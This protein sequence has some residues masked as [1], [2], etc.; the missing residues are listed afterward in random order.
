MYHQTSLI[1]SISFFITER[2]ILLY[3]GKSEVNV[4]EIMILKAQFLLSRVW[5]ALIHCIQCVHT[6]FPSKPASTLRFL[7]RYTETVVIYRYFS[8]FWTLLF[9][10]EMCIFLEF[11]IILTHKSID[12][13]LH[14]VYVLII[15]SKCRN[16]HLQYIVLLDK[17]ALSFSVDWCTEEIPYFHVTNSFEGV[18]NPSCFPPGCVYVCGMYIDMY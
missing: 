3:K 14:G 7:F 10:G 11:P 17:N 6:C 2:T 5:S 8:S 12:V 4:G 16:K 1:L 15:S 18:S 9:R 13:I